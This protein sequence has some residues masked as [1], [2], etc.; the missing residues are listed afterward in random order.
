MSV[1]KTIAGKLKK[2][3]YF[4][5]EDIVY[6][7]LSNDHSKSGK[8]GHAKNRINAEGLFSQS[9]KSFTYP[10]DTSIDMPEILKKN[11]TITNLGPEFISLMDSE[12]YESF[13]VRWPDDEELVAKLKDL[14]ANQGKIA[15][16]LVEY[17]NVQGT[18][19]IERVM[20]V[21]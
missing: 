4:I 21:T 18:R 3:N 13:D 14:Q 5:D 15:E 2:G 8:H 12:T 20:N 7:V 19:V 17:W 16:A 11:A 6:R 9:H 10:S 1:R